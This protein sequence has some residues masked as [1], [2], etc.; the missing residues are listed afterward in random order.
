MS[1]RKRIRRVDQNGPWTP[2]AFAGLTGWWRADQGT[3]VVTGVSQWAAINAPSRTFV[4]ATGD[5]QPALTTQALLGGQA[6]LR[7]DGTDDHLASA[8]T[9]NQLL[10]STGY[11]LLLVCAVNAA[12][13]TNR[14][15]FTDDGDYTYLLH[16]AAAAMD[17]ERWDGNP[18]YKSATRPLAINTGCN[19]IAT[20]T[21]SSL[22]MSVNGSETSAATSVGN[23]DGSG[24][25]KLF[26]Y[27]QV[28]LQATAIDIAEFVTLRQALSASD[29]LA[30]NAYVLKR[31]GI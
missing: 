23:W 3:T 16:T 2:N 10:A 4:Q 6:V 5:K 26:S 7:G 28:G 1:R 30:W 21:G 9:L 29:R 12:P 14:Y 15:I 11:S 25:L 27:N 13:A 31:Y 24:V 18:N 8:E 22:T 17:H 20:F 19:M